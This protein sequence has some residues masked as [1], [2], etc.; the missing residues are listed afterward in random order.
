MALAELQARLE[1][2][3]A[4]HERS[5]AQLEERDG[6]LAQ[7]EGMLKAVGAELTATRDL[8]GQMQAA[9]SEA[10]QGEQGAWC[11]WGL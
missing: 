5:L 4:D 8:V 6:E 1:V 3:Q 9:L 11:G 7:R 2:L 10:E